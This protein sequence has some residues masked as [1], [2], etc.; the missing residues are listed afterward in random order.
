[1]TASAL[2][3]SRYSR[4]GLALPDQM[5]GPVASISNLH[6]GIGCQLPLVRQTPVV[7]CWILRIGRKV[8]EVAIGLNVTA[9]V[10]GARVGNES[11]EMCRE[12]DLSIGT[13]II[14]R[15][16]LIRL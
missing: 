3:W 6:D 1:M 12:S 8:L 2:A 11:I 16:K 10:F 7:R 5:I 14:R 4:I 13:R 15:G 9:L